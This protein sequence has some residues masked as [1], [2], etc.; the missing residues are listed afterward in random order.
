MNR[1]VTII[2]LTSMLS[3]FACNEKYREH[4]VSLHPNNAPALIHY[5]LE[6]DSTNTPVKVVRFYINSEKREEYFMKD[7]KRHGRCTI[8]HVNGKKKTVCNYFE[9][10]YDGEYA[11]WFDDGN[12]NYE[13][14]FN[15]GNASGT[16]RFYNRDGSLQSETIYD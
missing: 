4:V 7:D 13:G 10:M 8:W 5:F 14:F 1:F 9:D 11:E 12:K 16:W 2:A 3:F 6:D 15:K